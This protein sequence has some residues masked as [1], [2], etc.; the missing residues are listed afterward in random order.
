MDIRLIFRNRPRVVC[1]ARCRPEEANGSWPAQAGRTRELSPGGSKGVT[2]RGNP[3][4]LWLCASKPVGGVDRQ[5]RP[6]INPEQRMKG[7]SVPIRVSQAGEK[8]V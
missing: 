8:S 5:I 2:Q 4:V 7:A 6:L 1:T 3:G